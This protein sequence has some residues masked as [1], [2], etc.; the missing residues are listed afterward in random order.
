[1][2]PSRRLD[3]RIKELCA[4]ISRADDAEAVTLLKELRD[5]LHEQ[6]ER[7]S[8]PAIGPFAENRMDRRL[9]DAV[10]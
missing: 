10:N 5:A 1:M 6:I 2:P 7:A 3:D 4:Q 8:H 9:R